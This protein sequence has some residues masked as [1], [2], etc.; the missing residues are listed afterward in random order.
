MNRTP[1]ELGLVAHQQIW[2]EE[3]AEVL[4]TLKLH[5]SGSRDED[6]VEMRVAPTASLNGLLQ[7]YCEDYGDGSLMP[8]QLVLVWD[9]DVL[10]PDRTPLECDL[11]DD[12]LLELRV[13]S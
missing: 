4:M 8:D 1:E 7:R 2:V 11:E 13:K 9:G 12:D 10:A 5:R 3:A 6:K